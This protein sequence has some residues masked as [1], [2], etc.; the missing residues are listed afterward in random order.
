MVRIPF[1]FVAGAA[2]LDFLNTELMLDGSPADLLQSGDDLLS[3][4]AESGLATN[5]EMRVL[6]AATTARESWLEASLRLRAALRASF[7]RL[8]DGESLRDA[9][10]RAINE[11]LTATAGN[12]CV[13]RR[14]AAASLAFEPRSVTPPFLLARAASEFLSAA[15][16]A[17][18]RRCEGEGCILFFYD[19]TKSHTRRWCSMAVCG[20]RT[21]VK[22]HYV[23]K[24]REA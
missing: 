19:T 9:D 3:W 24:R 10:L 18:V 8:A 13:E 2:P 21:K 4:I 12:L 5:A 6:R 1:L 7:A 22:A 17:L 15:N 20:N 11:V 16:L 23:R 14:D